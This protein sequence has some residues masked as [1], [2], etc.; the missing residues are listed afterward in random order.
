MCNFH[1]QMVPGSEL[2]NQC[3]GCPPNLALPDKSGCSV[4]GDV[5]VCIYI[6]IFIYLF[7]YLFTYV[8]KGVHYELRTLRSGPKQQ[9]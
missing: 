9:P 6:Y 7:I 5:K 2:F 4:E 1:L 3:F 8:Y